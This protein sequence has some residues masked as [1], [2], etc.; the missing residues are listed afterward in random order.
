VAGLP[1]DPERDAQDS[2]VGLMLGRGGIK[3]LDLEAR[4]LKYQ[5]DRD[6]VP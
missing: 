5:R 2:S 3:M 6:D 4:P 1:R